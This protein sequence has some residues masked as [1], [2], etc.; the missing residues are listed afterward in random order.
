[1]PKLNQRGII[2]QVLVLILLVAGLVAALLLIKNP[3]TIRSKA[4]NNQTQIE[5]VDNAGDPITTTNTQNVKLKVSYVLP[6]P[7]LSEYKIGVNYHATGSN[8]DNTAF[9]RVYNDPSVRATVLSQ[10]QSMANSGVSIIKTTIW[11]V[12][13]NLPSSSPKWEMGF[14]LSSQELQN[15]RQYTQDVASIQAKDGHHL[16]LYFNFGWLWCAEFATGSIT[17]TVGHCNFTWPQFID[18]AKQSYT[19]LINNVS[20]IKG[21]DGQK[22]VKMIYLDGE[23]MVGA[24]PNQENFLTDLY[25]DFVSKA[26]AAGITPSLYFL[27]VGEEASILDNGFTDGQYPAINGHKSMFWIYRSTEFMRKNNLPI[28]NRMDYSFYPNKVSSDYPTLVKRVM[29]DTQTL[30]PVKKYPFPRL[31]FFLINPAGIV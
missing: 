1:M 28:P 16:D 22:E 7:S 13:P 31:I 23:V 9:L 11:L 20:D 17:T 21:L 24:K 29:S 2:S 27:V 26:N 15:I 12:S 18:K 30:Y 14:P 6:P 5:I 4:D 3:Q 8:F 10:L 19:G 25:P